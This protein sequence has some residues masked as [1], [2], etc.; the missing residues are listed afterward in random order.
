MKKVKIFTGNIHD[1]EKEAED[2]LSQGEL[3]SVTSSESMAMNHA[4]SD[5]NCT[6]VIVI[7]VNK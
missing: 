3:V 7:E 1:I 6:I 5:W 2:F 4:D